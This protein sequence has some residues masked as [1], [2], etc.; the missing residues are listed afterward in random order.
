MS[1]WLYKLG[2]VLPS[3][4]GAWSPMVISPPISLVSKIRSSMKSDKPIKRLNRNL[5][6]DR[7]FLD[8]YFPLTSFL[9]SKF[10]SWKGSQ[11]EHGEGR[12]MNE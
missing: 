1:I 9:N 7:C 12:Q 5:C 4:I 10:L 8:F 6:I 3:S 11:E 2:R